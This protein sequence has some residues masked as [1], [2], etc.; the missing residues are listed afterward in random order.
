[1]RPPL[2]PLLQRYVV[3]RLRRTRCTKPTNLNAQPLL[4]VAPTSPRREANVTSESLKDQIA[5]Q[6]AVP[7]IHTCTQAQDID[8]AGI[9]SCKSGESLWGGRD[10]GK[11]ETMKARGPPDLLYDLHRSLT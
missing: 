3:D 6:Y 11:L 1:M 4:F 7:S 8:S 5:I 9:T 2:T 10:N